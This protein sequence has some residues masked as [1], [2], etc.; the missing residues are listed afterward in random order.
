M[1]DRGGGR[2]LLV[3]DS[4]TC[5][6]RGGT[7]D[8][9]ADRAGHLRWWQH[10][11]A[12]H[13]ASGVWVNTV[14]L[15]YAPFLGHTLPGDV[16]TEMLRHIPIR[17]AVTPAD[18]TGALRL[19]VSA[20]CSYL[21]GETIPVDGGQDL[22]L[23]A[24]PRDTAGADRNTDRAAASRAADTDAGT[25][26][27]RPVDPALRPVDP[28]RRPACLVVGASSG[29]GRATALDLARQGTDVVLVS[30]RAAA[31]S[32]VAAAATSLGA[33]T[34]V[35][36]CD[37]ADQTQVADL[38]AHA[39]GAAGRIDSAVYAAG[40]LSFGHA[41]PG[42]SQAFAVNLFGFMTLCERLT[43]YW[44][45]NGIRGSIVGVS[46]VSSDSV[47]VT[48]V[49]EYGA[50]KAAMT[51]YSRCLAATVA[52]DGIRVNC[53]CPGIIRTP[54][55]QV[56]GPAVQRGWVAR[57]PAGRVGEPQDV[58]PL[59][60]WLLGEDSA[61]VTGARLRIDGGFGLGGLPPLVAPITPAAPDHHEEANR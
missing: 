12:D 49:E 24:V 5:L 33:R 48:N 16:A 25:D 6:H 34:W 58:A 39:T 43:T 52:R 47:P 55:G 29:I 46:S 59:I 2:M 31:L 22:N 42:T 44:R 3:T 15:G 61:L 20:S 21:V 27:G 35:V 17:R 30:R 45:C 9:A 8:R 51:Q 57:I 10:L 13:A 60:T 53:V 26:A 32:E 41:P 4:G 23:I 1:A 18:L 54:M 50:S 40:N 7:A 28:A 14:S 38:V 19:F 36:T 11:A 56:A 37:V